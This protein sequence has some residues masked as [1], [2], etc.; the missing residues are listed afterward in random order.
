MGRAG[1]SPRVS[2][3]SSGTGPSIYLVL[4]RLSRDSEANSIRGG[5]DRASWY[6][7]LVPEIS[8]PTIIGITIALAF[9]RSSNI[10]RP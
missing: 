8:R 3:S 1:S 9:D 4:G 2:P 6:R 5:G 10:L 7:V